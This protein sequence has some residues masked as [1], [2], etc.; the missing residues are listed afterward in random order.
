[1]AIVHPDYRGKGLYA[2]IIQRGENPPLL[3]SKFHASKLRREIQARKDTTVIARYDEID[4]GA[5]TL[6]IRAYHD[7]FIFGKEVDFE[8]LLDHPRPRPILGISQPSGRG[9]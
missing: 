5:Y 1:M 3:I 7:K 9:N 2:A 4:V 8:H 6:V